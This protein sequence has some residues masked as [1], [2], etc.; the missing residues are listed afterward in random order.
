VLITPPIVTA[1]GSSL[2]Y[3]ENVTTTL[4]SGITAT[5]ANSTN[6]AL[7]T[8]TMTTAYVNSQDTLAFVNLDEIAFYKAVTHQDRR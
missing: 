7:A 6:L 1:T 8:V 2:A 5:D 3:T 4:D